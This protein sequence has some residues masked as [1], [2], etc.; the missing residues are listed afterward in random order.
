MKRKHNPKSLK[1]KVLLETSV[2][3]NKLLPSD[4]DSV[5]KL[6]STY[7]TYSSYFVLYEFKSGFIRS[8]IDFYFTVDA[9]DDVALG[10]SKWS[11][12]FQTREIKSK[13]ILEALMARLY[14]S[15]Q[16]SDTKKY[17]RQVEG[18]IFYSLANF[19]NGLRSIVGDF[20][21][22]QIIKQEINSKEDYQQFLDKYK[23]RKII[24]LQGFWSKHTNELKTLIANKSK[25]GVSQ[26][27][28]KIHKKLILIEKDIKKCDS[29]NINK[30]IGDVVIAIDCPKSMLVAS[31]DKSFETL[32]PI[33]GKR[34]VTLAQ[35]K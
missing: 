8:L 14:K 16:T 13:L 31:F 9:Y 23:Q 4:E 32:F 2:Q 19:E 11:K 29:F 25:L 22:D 18:V 35:T 33:L 3:I 24:P 12:K 20:G 6:S 27:L 7:D 1:E 34:N 26:S 21:S 28:K 30:S 17:L 15:I 5:R 10:I